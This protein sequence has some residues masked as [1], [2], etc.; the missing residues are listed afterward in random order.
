MPRIV[1]KKEKETK[2][3]EEE[4]GDGVLHVL[5][6]DRHTYY[7]VCFGVPL[8]PPPTPERLPFYQK[9]VF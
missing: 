3:K 7:S 9:Y 4:R 5:P 2:I 8:T 6:I 1:L